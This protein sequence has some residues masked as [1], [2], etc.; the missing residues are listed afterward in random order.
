MQYQGTAV[1]DALSVE[2]IF[3]VLRPNLAASYPGHG[4]A[5][6]FP[7]I[8]YLSHGRHYVLID[9]KEYTLAA[10]QMIIYAPA[11]YHEAGTRP[12]ENADAA[13]LTFAATS[14]FLP[15]L[16]NRVIN[17]TA[18][19]RQ[20]LTA[21][22][23][24][25]MQYFCGRDPSLGL[26][27]MQLREGVDPRNLWGLKK[28]IEL[29]LIDV[30]RTDASHKEARGKDARWAAEFESAVQYL[31]AH[32][33]E[34]LTLEQIAVGCSMSVSKLKLL[35]R[36]KAGTGPIDYCIRLRVERAQTLIREG[37]LNFTEIAERL[38]FTSLHYFSR[39]FKRVT[40]MSPTQ[41]AKSK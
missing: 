31:Q 1:A 8:I 7:E 29:F 14:A 35:F 34:P 33:C 23:D 4:E 40:G 27:G 10:G 12:P 13:I 26:A 21:V 9:G 32:L 19:Q 30:Y 17:L 38:G 16:Y 15:T 41:Y 2:E 25:G 11:S 28:Q 39:Q 20:M 24:E 37:E 36:D 22:V 6:P 18:R 3:T 5:H